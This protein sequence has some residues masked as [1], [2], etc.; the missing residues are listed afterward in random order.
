MEV[1]ISHAGREEYK[2]YFLSFSPSPHTPLYRVALEA[3]EREL[4]TVHWRHV[5]EVNSGY[6]NR[7][8]GLRDK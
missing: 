7:I 2:L 4:R 1:H 5:G 8:S 3:G 6:R